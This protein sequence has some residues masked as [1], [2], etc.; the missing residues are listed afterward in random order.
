MTQTLQY[1]DKSILLKDINLPDILVNDLITTD[2]YHEG[3]IMMKIKSFNEEN[4][5]LLLK[6]ATQLAIV[7]L[8]GKQY[9]SI[10][11]N[12]EAILVLDL[13]KQFDIKY[14]NI[15][16]TKLMD[17]ELT[18]RR[19]IRF[20]RYHIQSFIIRTKRPSYLWIKYANKELISFDVCFPGAEHLIE[21][22]SDAIELFKTY[23]NLDFKI[24]SKISTRI[25]R[26]FSTRG[27]L[28]LE[29]I[30]NK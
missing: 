9:G 21:N 11:H 5:L 4:Q 18:P 19:L 10:L 29:E 15:L 1:L 14:N 28:L 13:F 17:D 8:G 7:G 6:I 24:N 12:G 2:T 30:K 16:N 20:F 27:L 25:L 22:K 26:V 23:E 3:K